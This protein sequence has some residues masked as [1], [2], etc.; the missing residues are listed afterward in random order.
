LKTADDVGRPSKAQLLECRRNKAG[1]VA[2]VAQDDDVVVETRRVWVTVRTSR[3]HS[4]LQN[5]A[6]NH[7]CVL[8]PSVLGD[9]RVRPDVD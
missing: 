1:L 5:V 2:L 7:E 8:D 4:P 6:R 3:I 9:L